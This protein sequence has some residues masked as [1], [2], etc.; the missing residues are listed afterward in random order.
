MRK[1]ISTTLKV[2]TVLFAIFGAGVSFQI[3]RHMITFAE[4]HGDEYGSSEEEQRRL[5]NDAVDYYFEDVADR[6]RNL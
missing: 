2:I 5:Y 6:A 3:A 1:V 4:E